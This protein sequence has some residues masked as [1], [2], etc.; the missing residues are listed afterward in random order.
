MSWLSPRNADSVLGSV[1]ELVQNYKEAVE[2]LEI[3][4]KSNQE[5]RNRI[6][7]L[8]EEILGGAA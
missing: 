2:Y 7:E 6:V 5:L 4:E 3:S 8:E 1:E